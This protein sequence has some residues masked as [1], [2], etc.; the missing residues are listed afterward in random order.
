M[1][2]VLGHVRV[3][4]K[5]VNTA[6]FRHLDDGGRIGVL[7]EY[8]GTLCDQRFGRLALLARVVPCVHP[9]DLHHGLGVDATRA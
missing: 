6:L 3:P 8:I 9:D 7:T 1:R 2:S 5:S 4:P